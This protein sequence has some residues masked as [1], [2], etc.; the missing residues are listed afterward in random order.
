MNELLIEFLKKILEFFLGIFIVIYEIL[1]GVILFILETLEDIFEFFKKIPLFFISLLEFIMVFVRGVVLFLFF[2]A[3]IF[4]AIF[5]I[6][7]L[8]MLVM[9]AFSSDFSFGDITLRS[10]IAYSVVCFIV[11]FVAFLMYIYYKNQNECDH[12]W[13]H[14]KDI[15]KREWMVGGYGSFRLFQDVSVGSVYICKLCGK[16]EETYDDPCR[17]E[18]SN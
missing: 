16:K 15:T 2:I 1:K 9:T 3:K 18:N 14:E 7:F 5:F 4:I 10:L 13:R 6:V 11:F 17:G 12:Q 8:T